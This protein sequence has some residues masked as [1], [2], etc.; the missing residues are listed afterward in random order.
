MLYIGNFSFSDARE[1]FDNICLMPAIVEAPDADTA[2]ERFAAMLK[3]MH[4]NSPL[5]E[6]AKDIYLD[7][8][9]QV[10]EL[11]EE[12]MVVQWQKLTASD[13]GLYSVLSALPGE[14]E[15]A[16]A[17]AWGPEE[18]LVDISATNIEL[19]A[20]EATAEELGD[21]EAEELADALADVFVTL[22]SGER[23]LADDGV[24]EEAFISF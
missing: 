10:E 2:L 1:E 4:R 17:Y 21:D 5:M 15:I 3:D 8:L 14:D 11:P 7:S 18:E 12:P 13:D 16:E 24:D 19:A 23:T 20:G 9:V 6:G 22:S